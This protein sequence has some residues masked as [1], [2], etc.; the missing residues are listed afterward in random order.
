MNKTYFNVTC[1]DVKD[2]RRLLEMSP[3]AEVTERWS[4]TDVNVRLD[5]HD[6]DD[7]L[8]RADELNIATRML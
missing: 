4:A 1:S 3:E 5:D 8:E 6:V 7:F 2:L